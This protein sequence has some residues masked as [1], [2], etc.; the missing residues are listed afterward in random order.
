MLLAILALHSICWI[1]F[2]AQIHQALN[3]APLVS[4]FAQ[5]HQQQ[6]GWL[7]FGSNH[8]TYVF[9]LSNLALTILISWWQRKTLRRAA[10]LSGITRFLC[11]SSGTER[12]RQHTRFYRHQTSANGAGA[13]AS[14][15]SAQIKVSPSS[16]SLFIVSSQQQQQQSHQAQHPSYHYGPSYSSG[17]HQVSQHLY[18]QLSSQQQQQQHIYDSTSAI[19]LVGNEQHHRFNMLLQQQQ[20]QQPQRHLHQLH[21]QDAFTLNRSLQQQQRQFAQQQLEQ[22]QLMTLKPTSMIQADNSQLLI[23]DANQALKQQQQQ[24]GLN[25]QSNKTTYLDR[26]GEAEG[27]LVA[28]TSSS[29]SNSSSS[30]ASTTNNN[31][32]HH[33]MPA[34]FGPNSATHHHQQ[35]Q[36]Q[37][38]QHNNFQMMS[39][40]HQLF[41][42]QQDQSAAAVASVAS[43][44]INCIS[45]SGASNEQQQ[46]PTRHSTLATRT[47]AA[48]ANQHQYC[49]I[50]NPVGGNTSKNYTDALKAA[51]LEQQHQ[52]E[53]S[54]ALSQQPHF[55]PRLEAA[56]NSI[57][58]IGQTTGISGAK[59]NNNNNN[60]HLLL[61]NH[62][63]Q[64]ALL[65]HQADN[66][67]IYDVANY[68]LNQR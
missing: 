47:S 59:H 36:F 53:S 9:T 48:D 21:Q 20:Q 11:A 58:S 46:Q 34:T 60:N 65:R 33:Q 66:S 22:R 37:Q 52:H 50:N 29:A 64:L 38:E 2:F 5:H 32:N 28:F 43:R 68:A 41:S 4:S 17:S 57:S 42:H 6:R 40:E 35:H 18:Q 8:L 31:N 12:S 62:E 13:K 67:N 16:Q 30:N 26:S 44:T 24:N 7:K 49:S 61:H 10:Q 15:G 63:Q 27:P 14:N 55:R 1:S 56:A 19:N 51:L 39:S 45:G 54:L 25:C 3:S 23:L